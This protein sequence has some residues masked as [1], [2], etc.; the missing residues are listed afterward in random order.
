MDASYD[1]KEKF[2]KVYYENE[3]KIKFQRYADGTI[4]QKTSIFFVVL[5]KP[6]AN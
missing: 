1:L 2:K 3:D 6:S 4:C 5:P